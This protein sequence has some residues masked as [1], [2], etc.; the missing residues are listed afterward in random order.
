MDK[1]N[2]ERVIG[3]IN[4]AE[5]MCLSGIERKTF[6]L[7]SILTIYPDSNSE[8]LGYAIDTIVSI[9]KASAYP[10]TNKFKR[11]EKMLFDFIISR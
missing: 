10:T 7:D 1:L 11:H 2:T 9:S 8:I 6:V 4:R 5:K 3:F